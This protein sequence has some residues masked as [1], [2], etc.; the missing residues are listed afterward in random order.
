MGL[1][2]DSDYMF[3]PEPGEDESLKIEGFHILNHSLN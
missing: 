1:A 3:D 2:T